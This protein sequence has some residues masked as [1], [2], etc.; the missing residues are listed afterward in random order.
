MSQA[1]TEKMTNV[2]ADECRAPPAFCLPSPLLIGKPSS[3]MRSE[4]AAPRKNKKSGP[5]LIVSAL[6]PV[7]RGTKHYLT[8]FSRQHQGATGHGQRKE[9]SGTVSRNAQGH[10]LRGEENPERPSQDGEGRTVAGVESR[11]RKTRDRD[12]GARRASREGVRR[13]R[14]NAAR[15]DLRCHH[16]HHR[17]RPGGDEGVQGC[18]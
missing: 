4:R 6:P 13:N 5:L 15:E 8:C 1:Q 7:A 11:L 10:L 14:R 12:R 2:C 3:G 18:A 16:G 9:P 17:G